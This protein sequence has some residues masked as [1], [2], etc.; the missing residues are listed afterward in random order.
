MTTIYVTR[1]R[2]FRLTDASAAA[3]AGGRCVSDEYHHRLVRACLRVGEQFRHYY[4]Q[5]VFNDNDDSAIHTITY[6]HT[7]VAIESF[8][9]TDG[10]GMSHRW[11]SPL[12]QISDD[13]GESARILASVS[14]R[15]NS[16][17][18]QNAKASL[19]RSSNFS[20]TA[21]AASS[22]SSSSSSCCSCCLNS[23][24]NSYLVYAN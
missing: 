12:P 18:V 21:A 8:G 5:V 11:N 2:H 22:S 15:L 13:H 16:V 6:T 24:I 19:S 9:P 17:T 23:N 7:H 20:F 10:R 1:R 3:A 4:R 14:E